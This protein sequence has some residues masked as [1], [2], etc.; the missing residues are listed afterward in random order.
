MLFDVV[1]YADS[2]YHV[3]FVRK[4]ILNS[5]NLKIQVE[6]FNFLPWIDFL[7]NGKEF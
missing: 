3:Y 6:F 4:S 5:Q 7:N 2:E 1:F